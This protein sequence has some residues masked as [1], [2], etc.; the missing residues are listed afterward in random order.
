MGSMIEEAIHLAVE[1]LAKQNLALAQ[2]IIDGDDQID[3]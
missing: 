2:Q 1:S 3:E